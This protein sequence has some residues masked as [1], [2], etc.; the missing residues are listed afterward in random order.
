MPVNLDEAYQI[1][2]VSRESSEEEVKKAYKRLALRTH[3]G[4]NPCHL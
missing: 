4:E 2:G 3:P 1:L